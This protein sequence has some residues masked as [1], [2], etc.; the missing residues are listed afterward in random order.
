MGSGFEIKA[1]P[2][3][4]IGYGL[5][6]SA[7]M[8]RFRKLKEVVAK[9][10]GQPVDGLRLEGVIA[11]VDASIAGELV[12][13]MK[14][15]DAS[16]RQ[17]DQWGAYVEKPAITNRALD[18]HITIQVRKLA[19]GQ[20]L[21]VFFVRNHPKPGRTFRWVHPVDNEV[22][23]PTDDISFSPAP[24][25][26]V[27]VRTGPVVDL[28]DGFDGDPEPL[29]D[30][31][32]IAGWYMA[33]LQ[34]AF[35]RKEIGEER[36]QGVVAMV[37]FRCSGALLNELEGW[38][39]QVDEGGNLYLI[40]RTEVADTTVAVVILPNPLR[41]SQTGK[42]YDV[43]FQV[44][45]HPVTGMPFMMAFDVP[46]IAKPKVK[47]TRKARLLVTD[48]RSHAALLR[49]VASDFRADWRTALK[50]HGAITEVPKMPKWLAG[51]PGKK[52]D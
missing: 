18:E 43:V 40:N 37:S 1:L 10:L 8:S 14:V 31:G 23:Q 25:P 30:L 51:R 29:I 50:K 44:G 27:Q 11:V 42:Q 48:V 20:P 33:F 28:R 6:V 19:P 16:D 36:I 26:H 35:G 5:E 24:S 15:G 34:K 22:E 2:G 32:D 52:G 3:V 17:E 7:L 49:T 45:S 4:H 47:L 38:E 39:R 13:R 12:A 21:V 46:Q 41:E 9:R